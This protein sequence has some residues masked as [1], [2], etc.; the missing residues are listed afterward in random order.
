MYKTVKFRMLAACIAL[1]ILFPEFALARAGGGGGGGGKAGGLIKLAAWVIFGIYSVVL[2]KFVIKKSR[3]SRKVL[4]EINKIDEFWDID[5]IKK[6]IEE[7][8][9]VVQKAWLTRD[10]NIAKEFVT[11]RLFDKHKAQTDL[12]IEQH[13]IN[14]LENINLIKAEIVEVSDFVDN[15]KDF[16]YV[17]IKGSMIDYYIDDRTRDVVSGDC[18]HDQTFSEVWKFVR[19]PLGWM[20]DE[21]SQDAG[22]MKIMGFKSFSEEVVK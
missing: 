22:L 6:R 11:K 10:Q 9:F 4:E 5:K 20:L 18:V 2:A 17:F 16:F 21:I 14:K 15:N 1:L 12:M 19:E 8:F 13:R 3:E 7:T